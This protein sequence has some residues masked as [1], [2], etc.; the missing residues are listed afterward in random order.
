MSDNDRS[1]SGPTLNR[2]ASD[3]G[4]STN[5]MSGKDMRPDANADR[6]ATDVDGADEPS[7]ETAGQNGSND[8]Q[9]LN[10]GMDNDTTSAA[11][12][13]RQSAPTPAENTMSSGS[14]T[15]PLA[16]AEDHTKPTQH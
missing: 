13:A 11:P 15:T 4:A 7:G 14:N 5:G 8:T 10:S 6:A 9:S 3:E 1:A 2:A 12:E 16:P